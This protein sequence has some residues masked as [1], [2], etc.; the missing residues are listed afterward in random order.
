MTEAARQDYI[1]LV[2]LW[3]R[4]FSMT[5]EDKEP[6]GPVPDDAW[7]SLAPSEKLLIAAQSMKGCE[8]VL[9]YGSGSGWAGIIMARSGCKSVTCADP[10]PNAKE[11]A[12][13][14]AAQFGVESQVHPLCISDAWLSGVPEGTYDGFFCSNVL[15]VVP[16]DMAEDILRNAARIVTGN[17]RVVISLN[18]YLTPEA[19]RK[20]GVAFREGN[21]LYMD[22]VLRLVNR[23]DEEWRAIFAPYFQ[24]DHLEY[25]SWPDEPKETRRLFYLKPTRR[26][27]AGRET[28]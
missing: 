20:R 21:R 16:P 9:D 13:F 1:H 7:K 15:D 3:N 23:T 17:A 22:G 4:A 28:P 27:Q 2:D 19:A 5:R 8:N 12:A 10:A 14:Y 6:S 11:A 18:F 24:V 26:E 25:F